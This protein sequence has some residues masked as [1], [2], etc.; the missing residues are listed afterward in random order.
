MIKYVVVVAGNNKCVVGWNMSSIKRCL[1][2]INTSAYIHCMKWN[3]NWIHV[4][5]LLFKFKWNK[6]D[7]PL[8]RQLNWLHIK[9]IFQWW[10]RNFFEYRFDQG[11]SVFE[12]EKNY[13][14]GTLCIIRSDLDISLQIAWNLK[15]RRKRF[16]K[17][18][19]LVLLDF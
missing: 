16:Q 6:N 8:G 7:W 19:P 11:F 17:F 3:Y 9:F 12:T 14:H 1:I 4:C 18:R 15:L 2:F 13:I 10:K 5:I